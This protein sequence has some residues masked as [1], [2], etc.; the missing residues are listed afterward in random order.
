MSWRNPGGVLALIVLLGL[1]DGSYAQVPAEQAKEKTKAQA[2][3]KAQAQRIPDGVKVER[4]LEFARVGETALLL[5]LYRPE[6]SGE[7]LPLV[8]W[9]HGGG[10]S[11]GD[12]A[13]NVALP[14][15]GR[16]YVVASVNYRLSGVASFPAQIED[17]RAAIRWLRANASRYHIDPKRVGVWGGSA[18]GHLV[19]LLG[20]AGDVAKW[21]TVGGHADQSARVQAVC[22]YY[23][24]TQ[25]DVA[26]EPGG[27]R[28][29]DSAV[30][31][32]LGGAVDERKDAARQASPMTYVS[33][34]DPPFLILHGEDDPTVP[35][36]QSE[37]FD[38]A[39]RKAGVD[40]TFIRVKAAG[41]GFRPGSDPS[42]E[43]IRERV[44]AF[45]DKHL[46]PE[47]KTS[48]GGSGK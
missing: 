4:D 45:F 15:S 1:A 10:W 43:E 23:G 37:M 41:H 28:G 7:A 44:I 42:P 12:K 14:L 17:C 8:V 5:D 46:K 11:K 26:K 38:T 20:T 18:G 47:T 27:G 19:A 31:R 34:D 32:L 16:G 13:N 9:V 24:P 25:L 30:G 3:A 6:S 21:D 40:S 39:L 29:A 35:I 22:D 36:E 33:A 2:K 48:G